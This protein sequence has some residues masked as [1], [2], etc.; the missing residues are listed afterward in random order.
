MGHR[1]KGKGGKRKR[2]WHHLGNQD[3]IFRRA[4]T[5]LD[6]AQ[7]RAID[8]VEDAYAGELVARGA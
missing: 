6:N 7:A 5:A 2:S 3:R 4:I 1:Q 8:S